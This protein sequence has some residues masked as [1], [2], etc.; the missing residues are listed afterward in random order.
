MLNSCI[1]P[2][3]DT[4]RAVREIHGFSPVSFYTF[5]D[6]S[7]NSNTTGHSS[8]LLK[9]ERVRTD[10]RQQFLT[11]RVINHWNSLDEQ[12]VSAVSVNSFKGK[13]Q[14]LHSY[15]SYDVWMGH[16]QGCSSLHDPLG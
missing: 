10:P 14:K 12:S 6:F 11:E 13:L 4:V 16:F 5:F 9:K 3:P 2:V 8:K 1:E 15:K 7:H